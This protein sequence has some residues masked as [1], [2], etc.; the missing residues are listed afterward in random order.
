M[1]KTF[2]FLGAVLCAS[3]IHGGSS[4]WAQQAYDPMGAAANP[5]APDVTSAPSDA[6]PN[7]ELGNL[8]DGK[9]AEETYYQCITCHSTAIIRQQH[10]SDARWDYLWTWMVEEQGMYEPD[11]ETKNTILTYL[12]T[13]FSSDR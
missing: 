12:K 4:A 7:P 6:K 8:P 11:D 13:H 10:L 2:Q 1:N 9:G 5:A 3:L